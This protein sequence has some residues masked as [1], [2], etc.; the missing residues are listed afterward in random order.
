MNSSNVSLKTF[1]DKLRFIL[2]ILQQHKSYL[3]GYFVVST[4]GAMLAA[5][6]PFF[7]KLQV[8]QLEKQQ[9][10]L[11]FVH[12]NPLVLF[13]ILLII[14]LG[15]QFITSH[16][17]SLFEYK[18][19]TQ[20]RTKISITTQKLIWGKLTVL[21][22]GFF[23]SKR[24]KKMFSDALYA[25]DT[26]VAAFR[27]V[28]ERFSN[29]VNFLAILPLLA[30]VSW[31]LL[32]LI[33]VVAIGQMI[34]S[35]YLRSQSEEYSITESR[36]N[37]K[38]YRI[39]DLLMEQFYEIRMMG[40]VDLLIDKYEKIK[41]ESDTASLERDAART[42]LIGI[43]WVLDNSLLLITNIFIGYQVMQ[44]QI[45]IGTFMLVVSYTQQINNFFTSIIS[46]ISDWEDIDFSFT[47][48]G[49][50]FSMQSR[51][52]SVE[53]PVALPDSISAVT[54]Q[55]VYF[56]YPSHTEDE[57]AYLEFLTNRIKKF[58]Q[59]NNG[60]RSREMAEIQA[61]LQDTSKP[62]EVLKDVSLSLEKGKIV[63]LVGRNGS[64]KTT[65]THLLQHHY[66]PTA[67]SVLLDG[68][69][70]YEYKPDQVIQLF[71][72][73]TQQPFI[74]ERQS[75]AANLLMG[76]EHIKDAEQRMKEVLHDLELEKL[77]AEL[78]K[79]LETVVDEDTS[80]SGGQRQLLALARSLIQRR[81]FLIFD[82]GSSQLD[83]EKEF[84]VLK[85]LQKYKENAGI[86]F[87]THRM[88]VARK[89]DYI[90]VIDAG[91]IVQ[92]GTHANLIAEP[93]NL[94]DKFWSMQMVE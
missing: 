6:I 60:N 48:L 72:W 8:D 5:V 77:I 88:S 18:F 59:E 4:I 22:A 80:F 92:Q 71:S 2:S 21:D 19:L 29:V 66:E 62:Q 25:S 24:N 57:R 42:Q 84:L 36:I 53:N 75:L 73:L 37:D 17:L 85:Q 83:A 13:I 69:P 9:S 55:N 87:I 50:Y 38:L 79:K 67:G 32:V 40:N 20:L 44:G 11:Y 35:K 91:K 49:F 14:P 82:E 54:L 90:Y 64:G 78:P 33:L 93:G 15:L 94:Y 45:S 56:S 68:T 46:S 43:R 34:I 16:A 7:L 41:D 3:V 10:V 1:R 26:V 89:A 51:I 74:M 28:T 81:P 52:K 86:L 61:V 39:Q 23:Q 47:K 30:L 76:S 63:A 12:A 27:F 31:K 58:I 70:I 65:I